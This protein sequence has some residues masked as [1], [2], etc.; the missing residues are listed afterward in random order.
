M[1]IVSYGKSSLRLLEEKTRPNL[2]QRNYSWERSYRQINQTDLSRIAD[3]VI[4]EE[5][6]RVLKFAGTMSR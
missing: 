5:S 1:I 6:S 2:E 3:L 4:S